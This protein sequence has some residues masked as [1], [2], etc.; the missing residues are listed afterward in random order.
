[1]ADTDLLSAVETESDIASYRWRGRLR[2]F[3]RVDVRTILLLKWIQAHH[4]EFQRMDLLPIR[5][6]LVH[7]IAGCNKTALAY[8]VE[9]TKSTIA[10]RIAIWMLGRKR[11]HRGSRAVAMHR[12]HPDVRVR[13]EVARA[14]WRLSSWHTLQSMSNDDDQRVRFFVSA[15]IRRPAARRIPGFLTGSPAVAS[16]PQPQLVAD[17]HTELGSGR[18]PRSGNHIHRVLQRIRRWVRLGTAYELQAS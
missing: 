8:I 7:S 2:F 12:C 1:M 3:S 14:L 6:Q 15:P 5:D 18:S 16:S 9:N 13:R 11:G 10:L 4:A 17:P